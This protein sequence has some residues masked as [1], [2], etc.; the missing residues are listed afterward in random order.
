MGLQKGEIIF[1]EGPKL[2]TA[3]TYV[4]GPQAGIGKTC[5][6]CCEQITESFSTEATH[7]G[8]RHR[9]TQGEKPEGW[10]IR[11]GWRRSQF[12]KSGKIRQG[13]K[14]AVALIPML[15]L[16]PANEQ[17]DNQRKIVSGVTRTLDK[18]PKVTGQEEILT[19]SLSRNSISPGLIF[20]QK[21]MK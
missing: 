9:D 21:P 11:W 3:S 10:V 13:G 17:N 15:H 2:T 20:G 1:W 8:K 14:K 12:S 19:S 18:L 7:L 5:E 6:R 16:S 4:Q